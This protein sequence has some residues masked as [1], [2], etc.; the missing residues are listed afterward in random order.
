M[1]ASI[2]FF[3]TAF[4]CLVFNQVFSQASFTAPDTVCV[5]AQVVIRNTSVGANNFLW[6]FCSGGLYNP[7]RVTNLGNIGGHMSLPVFLVTAK[8]GNNYYAFY[9]N[10]TGT[11]VRLSF[12]DNLLNIPASEDLGTFSGLLTNTTE[13]LQL[14]KDGD[15]WHLVIVGGNVPATARIIKLD[16]GNSLANPVSGQTDWGNI[17]SLDYPV[18][19]YITQENNNWYGFTVNYY[20][21]T[22][23]RF[24]F[25]NSFRNTP[26]ATN[27]GNVGDL[28]HPTGIFALK[29]NGEWYLFVSNE[30]SSSITRLELGASLSNAPTGTNI[31]NPGNVLA[32]PRDLSLIHD[33]GN[34]FAL[35]VNRTSNNMVRID[36]KDG[37]KSELSD[38]LTGTV[39]TAEGDLSFPH[40]ISTVFREGNNLYAFITNAYN[41]TLS[42][43]VFGNCEDASIASSNAK[44]PPAFFYKHPGIY[45]VNLLT[46][47]F[48]PTESAFCKN[49]VV[50]PVPT[51]DL[52]K[53]VLI[54]DG[55]SVTLDGGAGYSSY[56]WNT[57]EA[58]QKI[59]A[60]HSGTYEVEVNNGG[61][62]AK[63][64]VDII[65]NNVTVTGKVTDIDCINKGKIELEPAGG[66]TPY[67]FSFNGIEQGNLAVA[68]Q[69]EEGTYSYKVTD[70]NGCVVTG[71]LPVNEIAARMLKG[72]VSAQ[73]P[74]CNGVADGILTVSVNKGVPPFEY[75]I[76][77]QPFQ[78]QP[79]FNGIGAGSYK[80]YIR[81]AICLDSVDLAVS[82]PPALDLRVTTT[83]D[84]CDQKTGAAFTTLHGG[85]PPYRL[86][87]DNMIMS[88]SAVVQL[89][90]GSYDLKIID[91]NNCG[92]DTVITLLNRTPERVRI[93]QEDVLINIGE[94]IHLTAVNAPDYAWTPAEGLS[95]TNCAATVA[96]PLKNT[97][98]VVTTLTGDNCIKSDTIRIT[99]SSIA[100]LFVPNAFTP[101][102]DGI[103]DV[104]RAK[105]KGVA[106][107][108]LVVFNRWGKLLFE[109]NNTKSGWDG[110]FRN[111]LQPMGA[112][113]YLIEYAYY[114]R[115][116]E[117][118]QQ[119]GAFTL[120]R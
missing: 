61:C 40:S 81:N 12:G 80:V 99:V 103:N 58:S 53:D 110:R 57:L 64:Q 43:L 54:C 70:K 67:T 97:M 39:L 76:E 111:E 87:W 63:D 117:L 47:E 92:K 120:I 104:F 106:K 2:Y 93:L 38:G 1:R 15:G 5:N 116:N 94:T 79:I 84:L 45:T 83:N 17:G 112:Y 25:G 107:Y 35:V 100:S 60:T 30:G 4:F 48:T 88:S 20:N 32:G 29:E 73:P 77:G 114:G 56:K 19:L 42:R 21:N 69:L 101:N 24:E 59:V 27:F 66:T 22:V 14:V 62:S 51:P 78:S 23:T 115:E 108:R 34:I 13:G 11:L 6:N 52:G 44:N 36:F 16:F 102:D 37:I 7:P 26:V 41:N 118:L 95:C 28:N 46:D 89:G 85:T 9:T 109:T 72:S 33:C 98:Y 49:I 50:M 8:D 55:T 75:A 96:M 91:D 68:D 18:D 105:V 71:N 31:G 90:A 86:Y 74:L 82:E 65:I 10:N 113:V 3:C 119:K